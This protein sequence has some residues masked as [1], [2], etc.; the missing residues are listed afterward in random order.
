MPWRDGSR[1]YHCHELMRYKAMAAHGHWQYLSDYSNAQPGYFMAGIRTTA[2]LW[3]VFRLEPDAFDHC[4]FT[5]AFVAMPGRLYLE[6]RRY[7]TRLVPLGRSSRDTA[8]TI[9]FWLC[10]LVGRTYE[11]GQYPSCNKLELV[12]RDDGIRSAQS[13]KSAGTVIERSVTFCNER[14]LHCDGGFPS[15]DVYGQNTV[16]SRMLCRL[17]TAESGDRH[18]RLYGNF[19]F[20][21]LRTD[22]FRSASGRFQLLA[23]NSCGA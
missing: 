22:S 20:Y 10:P 14:G 12:S 9:S 5:I 2:L 8:K 13:A 4:L 21:E 23:Q 11:I 6:P 17:G 15:Y 18:W 19:L 16:E 1:T 7:V 3:S